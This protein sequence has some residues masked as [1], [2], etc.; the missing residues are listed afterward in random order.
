MLYKL[1]YVCSSIKQTGISSAGSIYTKVLT[2]V[3]HFAL[4]EEMEKE[5]KQEKSQWEKIY[6]H[7]V[8]I[9]RGPLL[10]I[11]YVH[12]TFLNQQFTL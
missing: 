1:V 4:D 10:S 8:R 5:Q 9:L 12:A 2:S 11:P 6:I 7:F 3:K